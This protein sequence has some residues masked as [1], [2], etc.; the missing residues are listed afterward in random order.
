M[1]EQITRDLWEAIMQE[2]ILFEEKKLG[3]S[4]AF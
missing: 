4:D 1:R 2:F 3:L